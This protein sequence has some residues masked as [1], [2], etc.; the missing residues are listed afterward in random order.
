[1]VTFN[2]A[3]GYLREQYRNEVARHRERDFWGYIEGPGGKLDWQTIEYL[4]VT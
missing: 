4:V 2:D 3:L 1:M